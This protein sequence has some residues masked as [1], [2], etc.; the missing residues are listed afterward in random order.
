MS[1]NKFELIIENGVVTGYK[2]QSKVVEIPEG[3]TEIAEKA[4][5]DCQFIEEVNIKSTILKTIGKSAFEGCTNMKRCRLKALKG[6]IESYAFYGCRTLKKLQIPDGAIKIGTAAFGECEN[7]FYIII[8]SSVFVIEGHIFD[9]NNKKTVILGTFKSEAE[10]Y[11]N[12]NTLPF[13]ENTQENRN[14]FLGL[15]RKRIN[16]EYKDFNIFGETIR[17]HSSIVVY[18]DLLNFFR[19]FHISF[20]QEAF[21]YLPKSVSRYDNQFKKLPYLTEEYITKARN[22]L[23]KYGIFT[24][25]SIFEANTVQYNLNYISTCRIIVDTY[26]DIYEAIMSSKADLEK[27]L[28]DEAESQITGLSYGVIG[29]SFTLIAHAFDEYREQTRQRKAAYAIANSKMQKGS[30]QIHSNAEEVYAKFMNETGIPALEKSIKYIGEGLMKYTIDEMLKA[31]VINQEVLEIY[32]PIKSA[33]IIEQAKTNINVDKKYA[34]AM[35]LK[36]YPLNVEAIVFAIKNKLIEKDLLELMGFLKLDNDKK[37]FSIFENNYTYIELINLLKEYPNDLSNKLCSFISNTASSKAKDLINKIN[38]DYDPMQI[39]VD[40]WNDLVQKYTII[41]SI[42]ALRYNITEDEVKGPN[43]RELLS[44][45][46]AVAREEK[47]KAEEIRQQKIREQKIAE[48]K[49]LDEERKARVEAERL[50]RIE[51][52]KAKEEHKKQQKRIAGIIASLVAIIVIIAIL[53]NTVI[54]PESKYN[55]AITAIENNNHLLA[56]NTL[57]DLGD[58]KDSRERLNEVKSLAYPEVIKTAA[59]GDTIFFGEYEQD[60]NSGN[61]KENIEWIVIAKDDNKILILSKYALDCQPFNSEKVETTW[62]KCSLRMWLNNEFLNLAFGNDEQTLIKESN[63]VANESFTHKL[64]VGTDTIDKVFIL[65]IT[66]THKYLSEDDKRCVPT[67]YAQ[68]QG[69][70]VTHDDGVAN[71]KCYWWLRSVG[72]EYAAY[73]DD[74]GYDNYNNYSNKVNVDADNRAVRPAMWLEL[75]STVIETEQAINNN[76]NEKDIFNDENLIE[77]DISKYSDMPSEIDKAYKNDDGNYVL[78]L[79]A[80]GFGINGES[81][82]NPSGEYIYIKVALTADGKILDCKTISQSETDGM[83]SECANASFSSQFIGKTSSNYDEIDGIS[84]ATMTTEGYKDAIAQAFKAVE[85]LE[86]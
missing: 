43:G 12:K 52:K 1:E 69:A 77:I 17:C 40:T 10:E 78:E 22:F 72:G 68:S 59:V 55:N 28:V 9:V 33:K 51:E 2:G 4:F 7:L 81:Y 24:S 61:G 80:A 35:S 66:E 20:M 58:Y 54:I 70:R 38:D 16:N 64:I 47:R 27:K 76:P 23:Q 79:H 21:K 30:N 37:I 6:S 85:I 67:A 84:G 25:D 19:R 53:L 13:K 50:K 42:N 8:P 36:M 15:E 56:Y 57:M 14:E 26:C 83:G 41:Y 49:R 86:K 48:R 82:Y 75:N 29:D 31:K 65:N 3:I 39:D 63:I 74:L 60:N 71:G 5:N 34:I 62:E 46:I 11:A 18:E 45:A 44:K 73:V 32:D